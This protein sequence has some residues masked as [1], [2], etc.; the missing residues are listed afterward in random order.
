MYNNFGSYPSYSYSPYTPYAPA[1]SPQTSTQPP[2]Q[3][4][5]GSINTNKIYATGIEDVRARQLPANSD[6]IFLDNDQPLIYRKT[7]DATGKM[8]IQVFKISPYTEEPRAQA[9][10]IDM[11][12]Y[13]LRADF[14]RLKE[15]FDGLKDTVNKSEKASTQKKS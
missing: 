11:S 12:A 9:P 15:E 2:M 8:D 4:P 10:E 1:Y 6:Y 3:M 7:T 13:V 5:N 14:E